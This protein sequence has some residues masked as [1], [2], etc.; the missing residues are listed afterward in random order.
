MTVYCDVG[1]VY[2]ENGECIKESIT[3]SDNQLRA[4]GFYPRCKD[5]EEEENND[6]T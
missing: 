1:C 4:D 5:Y 3:I 6:E 2:N